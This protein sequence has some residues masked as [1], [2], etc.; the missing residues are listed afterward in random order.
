MQEYL[1]TI[2]K[3]HL[4]QEYSQKYGPVS[5]HFDELLP[6]ENNIVRL[7]F[8][9]TKGN[10]FVTRYYGKAAYQGDHSIS[11][12]NKL[13]AP[14]MEW[15]PTLEKR[16]CLFLLPC[17]CGDSLAHVRPAFPGEPAPRLPPR[18]RVDPQQVVLS[19][20]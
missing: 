17:V 5:I 11:G 2:L 4:Q 20:V 9:I 7:Q 8:T 1:L 12:A 19:S 15:S 16:A 14:E 3:Q 6:K 18:S 13:F 10:S